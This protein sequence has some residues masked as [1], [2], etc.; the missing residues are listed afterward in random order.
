MG[1][2]AADPKLSN[3]LIPSFMRIWWEM[4]ECCWEVWEW[5]W[6]W[7]NSCSHSVVLQSPSHHNL[8]GLAQ[9]CLPLRWWL[10]AL[11]NW[12]IFPE[13]TPSQAR[14]GVI[15]KGES[16]RLLKHDVLHAGCPSCRLTKSSKASKG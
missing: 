13:I 7:C 16:F 4:C 9:W 12:L 10:S 14:V 15:Q 1:G 11:F 8:C 6:L 3:D 2:G 5:R